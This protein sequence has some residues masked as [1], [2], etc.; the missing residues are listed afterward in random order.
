MRAEPQTSAQII[1]KKGHLYDCKCCNGPSFVVS[2]LE[3]LGGEELK[4]KLIPR[5][6]Q[7]AISEEPTEVEIDEDEVDEAIELFIEFFDDYSDLLYALPVGAK[8]TDD[9]ELFEELQGDWEWYYE[10][11]YYYETVTEEELYEE[12]KDD[13]SIA[14]IDLFLA[15]LLD[16]TANLLLKETSIQRWVTDMRG[17][18]RKGITAQYLLGVG[19]KNVL[20]TLDLENIGASVLTQYAFFQ[21]FAEEIRNGELSGAQILQ[22]IQMYGETMT[23]GYEQAKAKAHG[24]TLPEYPADGNQICLSNCRCRWELVD[25][26]NDPNYVLATWLINPFAEHCASCLDNQRKWNPLRVRR[27][28]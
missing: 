8:L 21:Q 13:L 23:Y 16:K 4:E 6:Y 11:Y 19:G 22:R 24:I 28:S 1:P 2:Q 5:G 3:D 10:E 27:G 7:R 20:D 17:D 26:P 18:I 15:I 14:F 25:D 9:M 12:D